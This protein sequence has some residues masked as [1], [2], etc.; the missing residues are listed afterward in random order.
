MVEI[1]DFGQSRITYSAQT[2]LSLN[3]MNLSKGYRIQTVFGIDYRHQKIMLTTIPE[4]MFEVFYQDLK[5]LL[6]KE[7][8]KR[9]TTDFWMAGDSSLQYEY[10]AYIKGSSAHMFEEVE[11]VIIYAFGKVCNEYNIVIPFPQITY[12]KGKPV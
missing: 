8:I 11:R 5:D 12:H 9:V 3:T 10:E 7:E 4:L 1:E 6:G 2:Y